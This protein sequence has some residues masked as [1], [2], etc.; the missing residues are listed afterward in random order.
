MNTELPETEAA[1]A[2]AGH[3]LRRAPILHKAGVRPGQGGRR[4]RRPAARRQ[5]LRLGSREPGRAAVSAR[6]ASSTA[7]SRPA[8]PRRTS[9]TSRSTT[10]P[11]RDPTAGISTF[12]GMASANP[13]LKVAIFDHGNVTSTAQSYLEAAGLG[14]DDI[15]VGGLRPVTGHGGGRPGRLHR[16]G[17]RPAAVAA[18]LRGHRPDLPDP[19]LRLQRPVH[20]HRR[21]FRRR[22]QHRR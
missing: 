13:D 4:A 9:S 8:S 1:H 20:Q 3:R 2:A 19:Q 14:P 10:P 7:W 12:T 21:R 11:T 22:Q 18:G 15:Y 6:R 16:P 5:G 17:H